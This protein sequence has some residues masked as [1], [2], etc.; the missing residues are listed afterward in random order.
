[1]ASKPGSEKMMWRLFEGLPRICDFCKRPL[2][3]Q[4]VGEHRT[5]RE[6]S[7]EIRT[8]FWCVDH[9]GGRA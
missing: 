9:R 7:K 3:I 6:N 5:F 8:V 1:M 4:D 2:R